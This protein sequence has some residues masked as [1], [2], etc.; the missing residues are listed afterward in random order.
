MRFPSSIRAE[1]PLEG[2]TRALRMLG[3]VEQVRVDVEG[4]RRL[5]VPDLAADEDDVL[6]LVD[7]QAH[8]GVAQ[9]VEPQLR[10]V[11]T[12]ELRSLHGASE[13]LPWDRVVEP[14]SLQR[15]EDEI[16]VLGDT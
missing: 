7:Q 2:V 5:R 8:E 14:G 15:S 9:V 10:P 6:P 3:G 1:A 16:G 4:R 12:V 13:R 11:A